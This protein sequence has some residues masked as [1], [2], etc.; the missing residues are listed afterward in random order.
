[1]LTTIE[2][3]IEQVIECPPQERQG[4]VIRK[5]LQEVIV[6]LSIVV[7]HVGKCKD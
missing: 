6:A 7:R 2:A 1:M 4:P 5:T 3:R